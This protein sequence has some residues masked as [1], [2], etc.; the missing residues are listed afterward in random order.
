MKYLLIVLVL[1]AP[2]VA[3]PEPSTSTTAPSQGI[4]VD[5]ES[6][7]KARALLDDA[8]HALGGPAYLEIQGLTQQGRSYSFH[9]GQANSAGISFTR[10]RKFW[11]KDRIDYTAAHEVDA[12]LIFGVEVPVANVK[13]RVTLIYNGD[14]G[15]ELTNA[16]IRDMD[17]KDMVSYLRLRHFAI[18]AVLRQWINESGVALFYEGQTVAA[19]KQADQITVMNAK[20][21]AVT[22]YLDSTSHLPIKKSFTWRDSEDKQ[23]N[24]EDEV[25]D[26]YRPVQG[27]QIPFDVTRLFNG[28]MSAQYFLYSATLSPALTDTLFDPKAA[29]PAKRH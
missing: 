14:K 23:R 21:E 19:Q 26:N 15:Y 10:T 27:V 18:D 2:L 25:Y 11:D 5:S 16:G 6:A 22:L 8:I 13:T 4:P 24:I 28:E 29:N 20:N 12:Y 1:I 3:Q 17:S 9:R 7:R